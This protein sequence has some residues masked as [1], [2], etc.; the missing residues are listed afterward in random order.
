MWESTGLYGESSLRRYQLGAEQPQKHVPLLPQ[1]FGEGICRVGGSI[2]QLTWRERIALRWDAATMKLLEM[3]PFD[4]DGW[5]ICSSGGY[6]LT[7]DGSSELVLRNPG[8]LQP[9]SSMPVHCNGYPVSAINDLTYVGGRIWANLHCRHYVIGID[10]HT[11]EITDIVDARAVMERPSGDHTQ[12]ILN[13]IATFPSAGELLLSG[14]GWRYIYHVRLV[15]GRPSKHPEKLIVDLL[16]N[17]RS[18]S[19]GLHGSGWQDPRADTTR[20][21]QSLR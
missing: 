20:P 15:E 7:S 13:G 1:L 4:R 10:S 3:V 19:S 16:Y 21:G 11:G 8:T 6:V 5:G 9:L 12:A 18:S 17:N 14:K 2:W